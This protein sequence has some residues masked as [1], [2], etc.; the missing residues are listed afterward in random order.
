MTLDLDLPSP[1]TKYIARFIYDATGIALYDGN[2]PLIRDRLNQ[3]IR[4]LALRSWDEYCIHLTSDALN[5]ELDQVVESLTGSLTFFFRDEQQL[6]FMVENCVPRVADHKTALNLWS[7]PCSSGE[8][9]YSLAMLLSEYPSKLAGRAWTIHAT[10]LSNKA[11]SKARRAVYSENSLTTV[12]RALRE[13]YFERYNTGGRYRVKSTIRKRIQ[14]EC[15]NLFD[16]HGFKRPFHIIVCRN[17]LIYMDWHRQQTL[18]RHLSQYLK[19]GG[20]LLLGDLESLDGLAVPFKRVGPRVYKKA[21]LRGR[22]DP[23]GGD[24]TS[25]VV[26]RAM[27]PVRRRIDCRLLVVE[28]NEALLGLISS[29]LMALGYVVDTVSRASEAIRLVRARTFALMILDLSC[30]DQHGLDLLS[31]F[32]RSRDQAPVIVLTSMGYDERF[33]SHLLRHGATVAL[34]K[35]LPIEHLADCISQCLTNDL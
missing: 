32:S 18:A 7:V 16:D 13:K 34:S 3:R 29:F 31:V 12:P 20:Y 4:E 19:S 10:D 30:A 35:T 8:E 25:C 21:R 9:A 2:S 11:I 5:R 33:L 1:T 24:G 26:P 6:Q 28:E 15:S 27:R 14:F 17:L 23:N 22:S